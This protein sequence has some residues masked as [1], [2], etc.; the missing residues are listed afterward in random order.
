MTDD[1]Q[2]T[3]SPERSPESEVDF[4]FMQEAI[5][6]AREAEAAGDIPVGAV[7]VF[8]G[9]VIARAGNGRKIH[10]DPTA[11]AEVVALRLAAEKIGHWRLHGCTL[12]VTLE[13]C[14]MCSGAI[15]LSR[16][17]RVVFASED[18]KAGAVTSLYRVLEDTRLNHRPEVTSGIRAEECS[19][20]L[21]AFFRTRRAESAKKK[22]RR[23]DREAE[24]A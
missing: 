2:D 24:G 21:R 1:H 12:Y 22:K 16:V 14:L 15:I 18:P 4:H 9:E 11:H 17:D 6:V 23:G 13:P 5:N 19:E 8:E 7:I 3:D 20:M 10:G